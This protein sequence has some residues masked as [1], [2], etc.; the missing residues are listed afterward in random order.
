MKIISRFIQPLLLETLK[1]NPVVFLNGPRQSGKSTLVLNNLTNIGKNGTAASYITFDNA[2]QMAAAS[3]SPASFL[4]AYDNTVILDEVQLVPEI[5]RALK[6]RVDELRLQDKSTSNGRYLLTGSA[7]ILALPKLS[8]SLVGRMNIL[9]L[10]PFC[11]A[12]AAGGKGTGL[13]CIF[14]MNFSSIRSGDITISEAIKLATYPEILDKDDRQVNSWFDGYISTI[15]Q[16]DVK[17]LADL[18]KIAA[19]P[20]LLRAL[21]SRAGNVINDA[22]L[23]RDVGLNAVTGKF[24]RNILKMMFLSVDVPPW[25]R[26]ISKRLVKS[27][28]GY[29]TDTLLLCF[30]LD[31]NLE[32]LVKNRPDL[33]GHILENY[34]AMELTKL[35]S[36]SDSKAKLYHFRTSDGKEVDFV[37]EKPNGNLWAVEVKSSDTVSAKDFSGIKLMQEMTGKDFMGGVVLYSGKES[38]PFG[39][40]LWAVPYNVLWQ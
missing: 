8:E 38:V 29:L 1:T 37:L 7:N 32:H 5:F 31:L 15:L 6:L 12:E 25:Y 13:D 24:Y 11:T 18:E 23:S 17:M 27:A 26:N 2:T 39:K 19:L 21:A 28:K 22:D 10:F 33:F 30:M 34:V 3:F 4:S 40:N 16:R 9:T 35:L 14:S 20:S 36:F